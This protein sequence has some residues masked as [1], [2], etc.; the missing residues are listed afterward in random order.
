MIL[1]CRHGVLPEQPTD[2]ASLS[3]LPRQVATG[4]VQL[5]L[6]NFGRSGKIPSNILQASIF[7]KPY[8]VGRFLPALLCPHPVRSCAG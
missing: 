3:D 8:F 2:L 7:R 5:A 1:V 6:E 4:D